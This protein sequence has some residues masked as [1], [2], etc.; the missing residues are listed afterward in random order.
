MEAKGDFAMGL[1]SHTISLLVYTQ[2]TCR[3]MQ[4][5]VW[6]FFFL[7]VRSFAMYFQHQCVHSKVAGKSIYR[8]KGQ[9]SMKDKLSIVDGPQ[10]KKL[11]LHSARRDASHLI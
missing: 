2:L 7:L 6:F 10:Y 5:V 8:K 9:P 11:L 3:P 4:L 1:G